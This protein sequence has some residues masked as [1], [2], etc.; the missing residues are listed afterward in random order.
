MR[1]KVEECVA[2]PKTSFSNSPHRW[3]TGRAPARGRVVPCIAALFP[4]PASSRPNLSSPATIY[5]GLLFAQSL[6]FLGF[7]HCHILTVH[8][9]SLFV[10]ISIP[11]H[12][13]CEISVHTQTDVRHPPCP[14]TPPPSHPR[15]VKPAHNTTSHTVRN[16]RRQRS[17]SATKRAIEGLRPLLYTATALAPSP[18][19][20][21]S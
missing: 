3:G 4:M 11:S 17:R 18:L 19:R 15:N 13:S 8:L 16:S 5:V 10:Q 2:G 14:D 9:S 20:S 6:L 1:E 12:L 21:R 7:F